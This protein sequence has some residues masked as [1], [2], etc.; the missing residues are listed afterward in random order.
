MNRAAR[1]LPVPLE[2]AKSAMPSLK[3]LYPPEPQPAQGMHSVPAASLELTPE[4]NEELAAASRRLESAPAEEIL[5]WTVERFAPRFTMATAFGPEGMVLIHMLAEIAPLTPIFNLDTG[6]Q[7]QETLDLRE[8]VR[9]RYGIAVELKRPETTVAEYEALHGGPV[10][11]SNPNQCCADRKLAVLKT[12]VVGMHAWA[13]RDS[14]RS[15]S[16]PCAVLHRGL[17]QQV[18]VGQS[19]SVGQLVQKRCL[20]DDHGP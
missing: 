17:G 7:F 9:E 20:E 5:R 14:T 19:Q 15:N 1:R 2:T 18:L 8:K 13:E 3:V 4:L 10:Y 11:K 6:Y 12:A 16:G